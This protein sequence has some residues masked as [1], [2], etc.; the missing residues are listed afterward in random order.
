MGGGIS[1]LAASYFLSRLEPR[2][3]IRLF[4]KGN[5]LGGVLE[6]LYDGA[7]VIERSAD[8]FAT[9]IP[10]ALE[11]A[12]E[13]GFESNLIRPNKSGRQA[14]LYLNNRIEPIPMGFSLMQPTRLWPIATTNTLSITAKIRLL[15][16]L[17]VPARQSSD[18]ESLESFVTR[19]LGVEV[20]D[21]LVEPIVSGIFT[22][23]PRK[24]S[25]QA[26]MP[27][28]VEME[29]QYGGLIRGHL[30]SRKKDA[31]AAAKRASGA[32]Y[33]QF[34]APQ[35]GMSS[36]VEALKDQLPAETVCLE[37]SVQSVRRIP[38]PSTSSAASKWRLE[39]N[40]GD[41]DFDAI[42]SALPCAASARVLHGLFPDASEALSQI[43]YASSAVIAMIVDR[44]SISGRTDGFGIIV[45][46]KSGLKTLAISFSSNKYPGRVPEGQLLLRIFLGGAMHPEMMDHSDSDLI[47]LAHAEMRQIIGWSG[48]KPL[49]QAVIRWN[50]AMPQYE[51][52]HLQRVTQIE[53]S[54]A[55]TPTLALCGAGLHGVG[56][57]QCVSSAKRAVSQIAKALSISQA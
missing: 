20:F 30:H 1:G 11:L 54:L 29:R 27:Q 25:M 44:Q 17:W 38:E 8:N 49:W 6:T 43:S 4:E 14:F 9:L 48:E 21:N 26:T 36:W 5:R 37:T 55:G 15:K 23:D 16:E 31:A 50:N 12:K 42:I 28:F 7:Y 18:D 46:R 13:I 40:Q 22:A 57:P 19:R 32:R 10:D 53:E 33:D 34:M 51:V 24:L 2:P 47:H 45:P 41:Q 56:I 52:G 3:E 39:T 35:H